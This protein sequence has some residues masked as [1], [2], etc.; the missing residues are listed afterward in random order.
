MNNVSRCTRT[1]MTLLTLALIGGCDQL[2]QAVLDD[3]PESTAPAPFEPAAVDADAP[4]QARVFRV[5][6]TTTGAQY[7]FV[8]RVDAAQTIDLAFEVPGK[9][10]RM[11]AREGQT[12]PRGRTIARLDQTDFRLAVQEAEV[13]LRQAQNDLHR[14]AALLER[15]GI[16]QSAVDDAASATDLASV[17]LKQARET[18]RKTSLVAPFDAYVAQRNVDNH[19][20]I[21]AARPVV[22]LFDLSKLH[23]RANVPQ[24]LLATGG[25]D[26][27]SGLHA[28]FAFLPG[29][30]FPLRYLEH[31]GEANKVAQTYEMTFEMDVPDGVNLLPGMTATVQLEQGATVAKESVFKIPASALANRPDNTLGVWVL[32]ESTQRVSWQPVTASPTDGGLIEITQG[33][34]GN[35]LVVST[36]VALITP[37]MRI[38]ALTD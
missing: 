27:S 15:R 32:D 12:I 9:L 4:R 31:Q 20:N 33:L 34:Q 7:S 21:Q 17:R 37:D 5:P 10:T 29:Q 26:E 11:S 1:L 18:L 2:K 23:L 8:A 36:G 25:A 28:T 35:E 13:A 19:A 14:K 6:A 30:K 16:S 38:S 24:T 3:E 22:R